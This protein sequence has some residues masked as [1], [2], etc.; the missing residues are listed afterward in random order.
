M[1]YTA[2]IRVS[3]ASH[4]VFLAL[5]FGSGCSPSP[6]P[7]EGT[8]AKQG[9]MLA[10]VTVMLVPEG[11]EGKPATAVTDTAGSFKLATGGHGVGVLPGK[12]KIVLLDAPVITTSEEKKASSAPKAFV[13][14]IPDEYHS[15]AKSPLSVQIPHTG[16]LEIVIPAQAER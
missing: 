1:H 11:K 2:W 10:G 4:L 6:I 3:V 12:Y 5:F 14:A 8:V 7:L 16:R 15:A 9:K 13:S